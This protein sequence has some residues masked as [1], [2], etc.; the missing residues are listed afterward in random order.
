MNKKGGKK[1]LIGIIVAL[2]LVIVFIVFILP[3]LTL[4]NIDSQREAAYDT[5]IRSELMQVRSN[6]ENYYY[7]EGDGYYSGYDDSDDW[8][9]LFQEI[10][11]CAEYDSYQINVSE[12]EFVAWSSLCSEDKY[13]CVDS[14][15][16]DEEFEEK[17][18][19]DGYGCREMFN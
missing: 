10:P 16:V 6:A 14:T 7:G 4:V 9:E 19:D 15:G 18:E 2:V 13:Y 1:I 12:D 5:Q 17:V 8:Q 11:R 3:G